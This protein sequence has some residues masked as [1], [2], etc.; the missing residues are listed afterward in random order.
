M[1]WSDGKAISEDAF[2]IDLE[3][4]QFAAQM[5]N[6]DARLLIPVGTFLGF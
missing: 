4:E 5:Q 6:S 3:L 1:I 2:G